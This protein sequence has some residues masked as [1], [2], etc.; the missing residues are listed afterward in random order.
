MVDIADYTNESTRDYEMRQI[1][2]DVQVI[3]M[4]MEFTIIFIKFYLK[5]FISVEY[6]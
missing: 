3:V 2:K 6:F 1:I 4:S 5:L